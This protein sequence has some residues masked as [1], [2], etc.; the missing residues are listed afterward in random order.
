MR[1]LLIDDDPMVRQTLAETLTKEGHHVVC[2]SDGLSAVRLA[3][4]ESF[5]AIVLDR[6]LP[7]LDGLSVIKR[8]S[9]AGSLPP[10]IIISALNSPYNRAEGFV[11]G[12]K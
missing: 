8:L 3:R 7:Q 4:R 5:D 9:E 10:T 11:R 6:L 1:I 12:G 2:G